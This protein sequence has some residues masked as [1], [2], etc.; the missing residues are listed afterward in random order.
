V[1]PEEILAAM[2]DRYAGCHSYRDNGRVVTRYFQQLRPYSIIK[3]FKTAFVRPEQFRFE[4][5]SRHGDA[6]EDWDSYIVWARGSEVL[7]W[8]DVRPGIE[9]PESLGLA[10]AAA[11][12]VSGGSSHTIPTLLLP[13]E[14]G[15]R[16]LSELI[17]LHPLGDEQ[18][19]GVMCYRLTG[20]LPRARWTQRKRRRTAR[21][22]S[23]RPVKRL[24][25]L[26]NLRPSCGS[27]ESHYL[28]GGLMSKVGSKPFKLRSLQATSR[29]WTR[30][31][32][33][34]NFSLTLLHMKPTDQIVTFRP[35]SG[36]V[37]R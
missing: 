31:S 8:W 26:R 3:P 35:G 6:E 10:V 32:P 37:G 4:F 14:I 11:T 30:R 17:E 1:S 27:T 33:R 18:L 23:A 34:I 9:R 28:F 5:R 7:T 16:S 20:G 21:I 12:G 36:P 2:V 29:R 13:D 22:S 19:D 15:G 24:S 25:T